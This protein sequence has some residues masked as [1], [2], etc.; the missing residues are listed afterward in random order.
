M[1]KPEN[2]EQ[3]KNNIAQ[4]DFKLT[5]KVIANA[6]IEL[7]DF[8]C[9]T[10]KIKVKQRAFDGKANKAIIELLSRELKHPKSKI[11]IVSGEKS[12]NKVILFTKI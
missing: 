9:E 2:I 12:S 7:I 4:G 8:S 1:D 5:V 3:L 10:V 11:A 6:K